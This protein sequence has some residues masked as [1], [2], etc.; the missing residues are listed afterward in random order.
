TS[1][2]SDRQRSTPW[3]VAIGATSTGTDSPNTFKETTRKLLSWFKSGLRASKLTIDGDGLSRI[4][5]I[6][7]SQ[8]NVKITQLTH[9]GP[10]LRARSR[11]AA[12]VTDHATVTS[13]NDSR[14]IV[15]AFCRRPSIGIRDRAMSRSKWAVVKGI[16]S[17]VAIA[18]ESLFKLG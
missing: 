9:A 13:G 2:Q 8:T 17:V 6:N 7:G 15:P 11:R 5:D 16:H 3:A 1:Q 18:L 4:F 12:V 14:S 10:D